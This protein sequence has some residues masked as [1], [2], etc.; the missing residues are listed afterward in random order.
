MLNGLGE[1]DAME[2]IRAGVA[3]EFGGTVL[4][5]TADAS[6]PRS[7][8]EPLQSIAVL[9]VQQRSTVLLESRES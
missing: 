2:R 8:P 5:D 9:R 4:F 6:S 7:A 1:P 3:D